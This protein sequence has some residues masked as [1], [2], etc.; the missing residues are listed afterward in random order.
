[1]EC[2]KRTRSSSRAKSNS[3]P[4]VD[5]TADEKSTTADDKADKDL[6][7]D[8]EGES[9]DDSPEEDD[10]ED[11]DLYS[12]YP[13]V[14]DDSDDECTPEDVLTYRQL[15]EDLGAD[16][17]LQ[18]TVDAE[19]VTARWLC[20]VF[21]IRPRTGIRCPIWGEDYLQ[22]SDEH[23]YQLLRSYIA[24]EDSGREKLEQFNTL[25]DAV[26]LMKKSNNIIVLA[27][28]GI[29]TSLGI[30]DF[31]SKD[32][33]LYAKLEHLGISDP[34]EVFDISLF[35][36]DPSVFYSIAKDIVPEGNRYSPTHA[37][38]RLLQ[39]K[40]KLLT[41]YSQNIDNLE[42]KAGILP[43]KLVQCH[44][45]FGTATCTVCQY[46]IDGKEIYKNLKEG[47]VAYC[48]RCQEAPRPLRHR[49]FRRKR[50][51][52]RNKKRKRGGDDEDSEDEDYG[53]PEVGVMKPD[54]IFF[55]E[56]LPSTF[57]DRLKH[58]RDRVDL[59]IVIGTSLKVK[60]VSD[61]IGILP[62][63]VPQIYISR[64]IVGHV[65]FD[66]E[67]LGDCDVVVAELCRRAGWSLVHEMIP[68][69][70]VVKAYGSYRC[71]FQ[72]LFDEKKSV[73]VE[74]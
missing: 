24:R 26:M 2:K 54:I 57:H 51:A 56:A 68:R 58:D 6:G 52:G 50:N 69:D 60:P 37:F 70:Q 62:P 46:H 20:L 18:V 74:E 19:M 13:Y 42:S 38:I 35:R 53:A 8:G 63:S 66:I 73:V 41:N 15:L 71:D 1:M 4:V 33:G 16:D 14:W 65:N 40:K 7:Q 25:A 23:Y 28:A 21:G 9:E 34:Q 67:L 22:P 48:S 32:T 47:K 39:D 55:G 5:L 43:G 49:G 72:I 27:G 30:P 31:R 45:S 59:L 10:E 64:D 44:G 12:R 11:A 61:M 36:E 17:F 3:V 29:S